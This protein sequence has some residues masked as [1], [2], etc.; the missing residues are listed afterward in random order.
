MNPEPLSPELLGEFRNLSA[1]VVASAIET[2]D[3]RLRN[4]GFA[5]SSV[6]SMFPA[7]PPLVG[8]AATARIRTADPPMEGHS[9]Y[10]RPDWWQ[11][12][13]TIPEPRVVVIEDTDSHPGLG[14]FVGEVHAN[15]LLAL[16]CAGLVTNGAVRDLPAVRATGFQMFAGNVSV[17]HGYAHVFDFGSS[18]E[19]GGLQV[20]PGD[21]VQGDLHGVQT[22]PR[23]IAARVASAAHDILLK[24]QALIEQC[25]SKDF[26]VAKL[27]ETLRSMES[28]STKFPNK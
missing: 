15:I 4:T 9:Y 27:N 19:L 6:R 17:S 3:V 20:N 28:H 22:I 25:R 10:A 1:C 24:R 5:N 12:I 21:L 8:Y 2:F 14:A 23:E 18:V 26:T 11:Y 16:G 13:R 7:F